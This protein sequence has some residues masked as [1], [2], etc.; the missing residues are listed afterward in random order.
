MR[1]T[2]EY[3]KTLHS[4][5]NLQPKDAMHSASDEKR[6]A[7]RRQ[8]EKAQQ[9]NL[10]RFNPTRQNRIFE[11]GEKVY[12]RN[13]KRLGN[14]LTPLYT[15]ERVQADMGTS[16]LI[17]GRV[18]HKDNL[19]FNFNFFNGSH[20]PDTYTYLPYKVRSSFNLSLSNRIAGIVL[21]T[22]AVVNARVTDYSHAQYIPVTDGIALVWEQ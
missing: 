10:N 7:I 19:R 20:A 12:L 1:A 15:E 14:K 6:L 11:L 17:I 22:L 18:V 13:K 8:I 4:V 16:V 2:V 9:A 3:N 5:T 21:I